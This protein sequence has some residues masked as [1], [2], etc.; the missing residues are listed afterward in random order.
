[1]EDVY[2]LYNIIEFFYKKS[3]QN[4]N[5]KGFWPFEILNGICTIE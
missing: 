2:I 1:M 3:N 5:S 4:K